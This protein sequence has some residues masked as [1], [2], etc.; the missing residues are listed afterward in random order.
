MPYYRPADDSAVQAS[1]TSLQT[2]ITHN[3]TAINNHNTTINNN[4]TNIGHLQ[5]AVTAL[6]TAVAA[7]QAGRK[8][9]EVYEGT[10]NGSGIYTVV[11]PTP[12]SVTP[13]VNPV[14]YP[15]G[16]SVTRV[17]VTAVSTTGFTVQ[18]ETNGGLVV[19]GLSVLGLATTT[20]PSVSVSVYV[21]EK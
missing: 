16:N 15:P 6:Q 13:H 11:F 10:T 9:E 14:I 19:L 3:H 1:I 21:R 5:S 7:L 20:V 17:R 8:R 12:Y 18:T 2:Q 4:S